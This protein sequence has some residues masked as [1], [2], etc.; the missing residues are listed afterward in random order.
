MS[1]V[2]RILA[3]VRPSLT[4]SS[5]A[6][7]SYTTS[8]STETAA[9]TASKGYYK[10][11]QTRSLIGVPKS[12]IKVLKSLGLGRRIGRPVFQPHNASAAGKILK[13][14]ELVKVENIAGSIPPEGFQRTRA[15]KGYKVVGKMI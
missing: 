5:A 13:V 6:V 11:T 7:R 1:S 3:A 10:V 8:T 14:K 4:S 12:T 9:D 15:T 2:S